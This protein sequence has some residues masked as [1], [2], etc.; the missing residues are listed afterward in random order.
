MLGRTRIGTGNQAKFEPCLRLSALG[1]DT[2]GTEHSEYSLDAA[3][4][5]LEAKP[6][7][8][9][10]TPVMPH[11]ICGSMPRGEARLLT[12]G[13]RFTNC[14]GPSEDNREPNKVSYNTGNL[15]G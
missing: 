12:V 2:C 6:L 11:T 15:A 3:E 14:S 5:L 9:R 1:Y 8:H 4:Q 10:G 13:E 7:K